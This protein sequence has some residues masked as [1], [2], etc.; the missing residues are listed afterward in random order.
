MLETTPSIRAGRRTTRT[1]VAALGALSVLAGSLVAT[2]LPA[3]AADLPATVMDATATW[4]YSDNNTDPAAGDADRLVWTKAGFNDSAWKT[5]TT[6]FGAKNG[7]ATG[8]GSSFPVTTLLNQYIDPTASSKVDVP[9]FHFRSS[10]SLTADTLSQIQGLSGTVRYDDAV[11]IFV[12]GVQVAGFVDDKVIAAPEAQRNLMYAGNGGGDPLTSNY[13]VPASVLTAGTNTIAVALYQDRTTSSDIYLDMQK[14]VPVAKTAGAAS[15]SDIILGV[16]ADERSRTVNWYS[17]TDT[18]QAVQFAPSASVV[19]GAF[20]ANATTVAATGAG[21]TSGEFSRKAVMSGLAE[22]TA[23]SYR[24]GADG[25]WSAVQSFR[26]ASFDGSFEFFMV[27]DPQ[28]GSSGNVANDT[29]GWV[30]TMNVASQT[31]PNAEMIF[32]VGDQV[33][34]AGNETHYTGFLAPE[35]LRSLPVAVTNGNHDVGSKAYLQHFNI[36]NLDETA[37]AASSGSS[38]G[39]DYWFMYKD[40][41]FININSNSRD[42]ASHNAFMEKVVAEQGAKAKWKVLAFH[43][44]IYSVAAHYGDS[45]IIDRRNNMPAK[46]SELGFDLVLQ[47]HDHSYTRSFL[48]KDGALADSTEVAG[49]AEVSAKKGEVL[50]LTANSAS[51]SKYYGVTA[52]NAWFASVINQERVRN[53]SVLNVSDTGIKVTTLRSQAN[54]TASPVNSVVDEVTLTREADPNAQQ[55]QVEVPEAAPGEFSWN[56][57][58]TNGLVDLGTATEEGDH[59]AAAGSINPIRVTDT[60]IGGP[61]WSVSAQVSDF[62]SGD[63]TFSGKYLGWTPKV[64][65]EGAGATAGAKVASGFDAGAGLSASATLGSAAATHTRGSAKLGADLELKLPVDV[66]DGTYTA[67]LT[68]TALS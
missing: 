56:I 4:K 59:F 11:Q 21:T 37:G 47:G 28:I 42:Y 45:D 15:I 7:V 36:P 34:T 31:Y 60:R 9:T 44:S 68:L 35:Q 38:S 63:E 61:A 16:G 26:T 30:D 2:S 19:G 6:A 20:P 1:A 13:S 64:L 25:A 3:A 32:S 52:P 17:S 43:H 57:D 40:V 51:G 8:L 65:E 14:V 18:A 24:V 66:T 50:Y 33:E 23:Y 5:G 54:G 39:G 55:L 29:A 12:N 22:N 49:Q 53:Y 67:T 58:G 48:V 41:L 62:R 10:F 46:I 27:G